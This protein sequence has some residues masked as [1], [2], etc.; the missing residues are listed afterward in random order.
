M[1]MVAGDFTLS[2]SFGAT[3]RDERPIERARHL[4]EQRRMRD[5]ILGTELFGDP[6]W[7]LMLDLYVAQASGKR[8]SMTSA[9]IGSGRPMSTGLRWV[10]L[11]VRHGFLEREADPD[12]GRRH[13][14][15]LTDNAVAALEH[16]LN[17]D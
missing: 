10:R 6:G 5:D 13:Y 15:R 11:L 1:K 2:R 17:H 4:L 3:L 8:I 12:D 9:A 14:L 7:E 16:F